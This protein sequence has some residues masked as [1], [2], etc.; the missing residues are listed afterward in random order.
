MS[1]SKK[2]WTTETR[3]ILD[4]LRRL[5][6]LSDF[7]QRQ[8]E[9]QAG[10]S[11]GYLSQLLGQ[12]LDLKV[13]HVLSILN[14]L[15]IE[16]SEFFTRIFKKGATSGKPASLSH[17]AHQSD[18]LSEDLERWLGRIYRDKTQ[19]IEQIRQRLDRC[20]DAVSQLEERG[21]VRFEKTRNQQD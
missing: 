12:N 1:S 20:E 15:D 2:P 6:R 14:V 21:I 7:S 13:H 8:V 5:I 11:K 10:F 18:G 19:A 17:F 16:P 3:S 4:E 9:M